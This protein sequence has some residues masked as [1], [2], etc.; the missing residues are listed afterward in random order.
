MTAWSDQFW[1]SWKGV[2][3]GLCLVDY[4]RRVTERYRFQSVCN[5]TECVSCLKMEFALG[6]TAPMVAPT[7]FVIVWTRWGASQCGKEDL[8]YTFFCSIASPV[9]VVG[10]NFFVVV[11]S[12]TDIAVSPLRIPALRSWLIYIFDSLTL[13]WSAICSTS[14]SSRHCYH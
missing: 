9:F 11:I 14:L 5:S 8:Q 3:N 4:L 1:A 2:K 13:G 12:L 6:E 10:S 7:S